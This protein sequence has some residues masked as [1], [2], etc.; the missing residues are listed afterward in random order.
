MDT[1]AVVTAYA[2]SKTTW[3]GMKDLKRAVN[4]TGY[5]APTAQPSTVQFRSLC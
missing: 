4:A 2:K 1:K 3:G 5:R